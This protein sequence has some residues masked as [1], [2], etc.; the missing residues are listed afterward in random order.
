MIALA[1]R[2]GI[3]RVERIVNA[4]YRIESLRGNGLRKGG[5]RENKQQH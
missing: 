5:R 2:H 4:A 3:V 1:Q